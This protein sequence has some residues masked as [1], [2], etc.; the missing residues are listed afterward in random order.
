M[1]RSFTA[2][3]ARDG[4]AR[5]IGKA[6]VQLAHSLDLRVVAEG[7]ETPEQ[8]SFLASHG[9]DVVQGFY[10]GRPMSSASL[11]TWLDGQLRAIA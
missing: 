1:D 7:V 2:D 3:V 6:I 11:E 5:A 9:C 10:V 8:L 4:K